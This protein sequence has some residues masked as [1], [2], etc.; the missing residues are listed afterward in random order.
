MSILN[1]LKKIKLPKFEEDFIQDPAENE[2]AGAPASCGIKVVFDPRK[3]PEKLVPEN[4]HHEWMDDEWERHG[5][6]SDGA[7]MSNMD[8]W[9]E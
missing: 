6:P 3:D 7:S 4:K 1:I 9:E 2:I 5:D 8:T